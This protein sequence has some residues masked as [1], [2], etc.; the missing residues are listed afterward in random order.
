M[1]EQQGSVAASWVCVTNQETGPGGKGVLSKPTEVVSAVADQHVS[2]HFLCR[3]EF[4]PQRWCL[5]RPWFFVE[6]TCE[7]LEANALPSALMGP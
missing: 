6:Y 4:F 7:M 3:T 2:E 5:G 1:R